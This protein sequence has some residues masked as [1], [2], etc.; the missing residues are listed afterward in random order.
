MS[1][2]IIRAEK[3]SN[4][5]KLRAAL[6]H[7]TRERPCLKAD[8]ERS[9]LNEIVDGTAR[10]DDALDVHAKILERLVKQKNSVQAIEYVVACPP[11]AIERLDGPRGH[12]NGKYL[13]DALTWLAARHGG[14]HSVIHAAIH[15]DELSP[16]IHVIV[17]PIAKL[18]RRGGHEHDTLSASQFIGGKKRLAALQTEFAQGVGRHWGLER[19]VSKEITGRIHRPV[20]DWPAARVAAIQTAD[21]EKLDRDD[22]VAII[23]Q[24]RNDRQAAA[25]GAG[26]APPARQA[27][28][29]HP[30]G[31]AAFDFLGG[32]MSPGYDAIIRELADHHMSPHRAKNSFQVLG[33]I[34]VLEARQ[35]GDRSREGMMQAMARIDAAVT[36]MLT[37]QRAETDRQRERQEPN[38]GYSAG[39]D[40]GR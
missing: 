12:E 32:K 5:G 37:A 15:R 23:H 8:P 3:L 31:Q 39:R 19:G 40:P 4:V 13:K 7:N 6:E 27:R 2:C 26:K 21:L 25:G 9:H 30:L 24:L 16:H 33:E 34:A 1:Y 11:D 10:A 17:V 36:A 22:L 14:P 29:D 18:K 35:S 38:R 20:R 28:P